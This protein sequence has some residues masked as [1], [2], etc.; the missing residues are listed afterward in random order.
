MLSCPIFNGQRDV[1]GV[2]QLINKVYF[3]LN[4][5]ETQYQQNNKKTFKSVMA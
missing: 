2:A 5:G 3:S 1:I 4:V